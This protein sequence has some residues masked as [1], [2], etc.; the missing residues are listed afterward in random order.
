M[1]TAYQKQIKPFV[2]WGVMTGAAFAMNLAVLPYRQALFPLLLFLLPFFGAPVA[3]LVGRLAWPASGLRE[4]AW[5]SA[6]IVVLFPPAFFLYHFVVGGIVPAAPEA[7]GLLAALRKSAILAIV[8]ALP[9]EFFFRGWLQ[10]T[11]FAH[12]TRRLFLFITARNL[13]TSALFGVAHAVAFLNPLSAATFFPSLLFG[14]LTER[15][16]GSVVPSVLLHTVANL[17]LFLLLACLRT[18]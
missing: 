9:E 13:L 4:F 15:S 16:G 18:N 14:W 5:L 11:A 2:L 8:A 6:A 17:V 12:L 3:I 10:Q 1:Q 7:S